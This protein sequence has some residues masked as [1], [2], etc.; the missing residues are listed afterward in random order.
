MP[1]RPYKIRTWRILNRLESVKLPR[2]GSG[3]EVMTF[4]HISQLST[5]MPMTP[6]FFFKMHKSVSNSVEPSRSTTETSAASFI[7]SFRHLYGKDWDWPGTGKAWTTE[8]IAKSNE[9]RLLNFMFVVWLRC[10]RWW[11][12]EKWD[13]I[14]RSI[15][16]KCD[17]IAWKCAWVWLSTAFNYKTKKDYPYYSHWQKSR[18]TDVGTSSALE[19]RANSRIKICHTICTRR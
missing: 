3:Y 15:A 11:S 19:N 16:D 9:T 6:L 10:F 18:L 12:F 4:N 7:I 5:P 1:H 2:D 13:I 14:D 8:N 17:D